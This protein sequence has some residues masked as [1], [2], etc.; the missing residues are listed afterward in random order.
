MSSLKKGVTSIKY[1]I[2]LK[3]ASILGINNEEETAA[4]CLVEI[5]WPRVPGHT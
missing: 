4:F 2:L 1:H 3:L 5:A